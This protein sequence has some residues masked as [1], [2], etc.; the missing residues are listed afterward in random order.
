MLK[1]DTLFFGIMF[2]WIF[3]VVFDVFIYKFMDPFY[4]QFI[5]IV[6]LAIFALLLTWNRRFRRYML[7]DSRIFYRLIYKQ[8][9]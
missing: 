9:K 1:K 4:I 8:K 5:F 7:Q 6:P 3:T 2:A